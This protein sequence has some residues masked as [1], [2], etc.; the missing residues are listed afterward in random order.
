LITSGSEDFRPIKVIHHLASGLKA[1]CTIN[2]Y[3][4]INKM[5]EACGGAGFSAYSA[6]P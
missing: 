2:A 1:F 5:R 3:D 6:L 4:I